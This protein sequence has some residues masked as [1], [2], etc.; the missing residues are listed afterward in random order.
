MAENQRDMLR[1]FVLS[2]LLPAERSLVLDSVILNLDQEIKR[3]K[4]EKTEILLGSA[5]VGPKTG[6]RTWKAK[7]AKSSG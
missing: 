1:G 7:W 3:Y 4:K 6:P 5:T 2:E